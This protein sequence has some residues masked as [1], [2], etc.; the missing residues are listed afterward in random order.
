M[1]LVDEPWRITFDLWK[2]RTAWTLISCD[3]FCFLYFNFFLG[4]KLPF[5]LRC[6][7]AGKLSEIVFISVFSCGATPKPMH[8]LLA[9]QAHRIF[10]CLKPHSP[11]AA[12]PRLMI[13]C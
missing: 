1:I 9:W 12:A 13:C 8:P 5:R 11:P 4:Q 2:E 7:G 6:S 3:I 10:C